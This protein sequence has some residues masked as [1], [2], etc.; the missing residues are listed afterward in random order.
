MLTALQIDKKNSNL[1]K[2]AHFLILFIKL[3]KKWCREHVDWTVS[4]LGNVMFTD[5][6]RLAL[7]PDEK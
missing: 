6:P 2:H 4:D 3:K 1:M 7:E 5:E